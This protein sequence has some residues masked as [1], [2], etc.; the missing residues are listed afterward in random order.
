MLRFGSGGRA[1]LAAALL[2]AGTAAV[3]PTAAQ[4]A[5]AAYPL[6][7]P[8][9]PA[10]R[11][12]APEALVATAYRPADHTEM[13][14]VGNGYLGLRLPASGAGYEGGGVLGRSGWPLKNDRYTTALVAGVYERAK[15]RIAN[16]TS[17][18]TGPNDYI[19]ALPTWSGMSL[20]VGRAVLDPG[21]SPSRISH[22]RQR[23]DIRRATVTTSY[24]WTP[25][26]G[27]ATRVTYQV[28]ANRERMH[29]G[30]VRVEITPA[31]S[32]DLSLT[33]LL[34]GRGAE[35]ITP[36]SRSADP[37]AGTAGV[38]LRTPGRGT[39][40]AES[41]RLVPGPGTTVRRATAVEPRGALGTAGVRWTIP[42]TAGRHYTVDKYVGISSSNDPGAPFPA[43]RTD[44]SGGDPAAVAADTAARAAATGWRRLLR[45]HTRAWAALWAPHLT[46]GDRS[47]QTAADT[48]FYLL[49][50][51]LRA[52]VDFSIPPTGL[53]SDGYAGAIFWD[54]DTWMFPAL[55]ALHPELARP[56]VQ[57]RY[58]TRRAAEADAAGAG[59][60]GG[61]WPWDD[62]PSGRCGGLA[63]CRGYEDHLQ[64]DIAL[65][66][67][68]YY[69]AT[70]DLA[71][72]RRYGY[73]VLA[74]VARFWASRV[75]LGGDGEY[76][77]DHVT[78][79][80][81]YTAGVDD[82]A[83]TN[84]GAVVALRDAVQAAQR[85]GAV[86]DPAWSR[87]A[88]RIRVAAD[89]AGSHPEYAG[90]R[91]QKLKQADTV[92]LTYPFQYVADPR[93]AAADLHRYL[94]LTDTG[95]PAMTASVEAVIAAQVR[96][97]G[98]LDHSLFENSYRPFLRGSFRQFNETQY[99]TPSGGQDDPAFAFATGAGGFLQ[100]FVYGFA[101]LRW[102]ADALRLDPT[103]P[104]QL[105]RGITVH[106]LSY[107]GRRITVAIGP[108]TTRVRLDSGAPVEVRTPAGS[109]LLVGTLEL[110][111]A[112]P[113]L[114][115]TA[116]LARC[117]P[118]TASSAGAVAPAEAAVDG[119]TATPW[120]ATGARSRFTV[121][122]SAPG[123]S[124]VGTRDA[125]VRWGAGR[126]ARYTVQAET[127]PGRWT[128]LA[129]GAVPGRSDLSVSWRPTR[130]PA[131]RLL[132]SGGRPAS[133]EELTVD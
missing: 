69:Q 131:L 113:D 7:A 70:G 50:S 58:D 103:L 10:P 27:R 32:G 112:R 65:A 30:Q 129:S 46:V 133:I 47:A 73:P 17:G 21:V 95:G 121:E 67:W 64:S 19:S 8:A 33:G 99:L 94:P 122:L 53:S 93:S 1:V 48:S 35:R 101:G 54:A 124:P 34:D 106:G 24:L 108:R 117:R 72:L 82:E 56:I 97:P 25:A 37:A 92:L 68:Q 110:P 2:L 9:A 130:T 14:F 109:R 86:P 51:S 15:L 79:P 59:Y 39:V 90:Y 13:P 104:P 83:A 28:L 43:S 77:I 71:W 26:P 98:C 74:D 12:G 44:A 119:D 62:G 11:G 128:T 31:W 4:A 85:I 61:A 123:R 45:E 16:G 55:L 88:D 76:H 102:D 63:P 80:D 18:A 41:E 115:P 49:Y 105:S 38:R 6:A 96:P 116:D 57:F 120:T 132:L 125:R 60:R 29:L 81:E 20:G 89:P 40:A 66:Q 42:V 126:P 114:T 100:T 84:G 127:A 23:L 111:T 5:H 91:N 22:Y 118:A 52:G 87:I 75:R 107:Q 3:P 36:V 78:G